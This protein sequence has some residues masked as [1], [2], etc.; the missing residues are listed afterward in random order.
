[1]GWLPNINESMQVISLRFIII[2]VLCFAW[3]YF[4]IYFHSWLICIFLKYNVTRTNYSGKYLYH[5]WVTAVLQAQFLCRKTTMVICCWLRGY[6]WFL[7]IFF[8]C[9][10]SSF[11]IR[12]HLP[13]QLHLYTKATLVLSYLRCLW[14]CKRIRWHW[15]HNL[16]WNSRIIKNEKSAECDNIPVT[17]LRV[18][19]IELA[20]EFGIN[21]PRPTM[22]NYSCKMMLTR[23]SIATNILFIQSKVKH[24]ATMQ[25]LCITF[26]G[27]CSWL[28]Y[29]LFRFC[30][31]CKI[32]RIIPLPMK[33]VLLFIAVKIS[34]YFIDW[35]PMR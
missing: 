10:P 27:I 21:T 12:I 11:L 29:V 22:I 16:L 31:N 20:R 6:C 9:C 30:I 35:A 13:V 24:P 5:S 34:T 15:S 7:W 1:M 19:H 3:T 2:H 32:I 23:V 4:Q 17:S 14:Y 25:L 33:N 28:C 18:A 26:C 8:L